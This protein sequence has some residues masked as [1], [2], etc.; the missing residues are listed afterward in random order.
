MPVET[1]V[2]FSSVLEN[3]ARLVAVMVLESFVA[4]IERPS[5]SP[6]SALMAPRSAISRLR[7]AVTMS[8]S[9]GCPSAGGSPSSVSRPLISSRRGRVETDT[10]MICLASAST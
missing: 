9:G 3:S 10:P 1:S 7:S 4:W 8:A 2:F 5:A 6:V